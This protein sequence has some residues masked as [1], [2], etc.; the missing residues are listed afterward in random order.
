MAQTYVWLPIEN[1][2][3]ISLELYLPWLQYNV[4]YCIGILW[5][6]GHQYIRRNDYDVFTDLGTYLVR[7]QYLSGATRIRFLGGG[8]GVGFK[9]KKLFTDVWWEKGVRLS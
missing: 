9:K 5:S 3:P 1:L 2:N 7:V 4:G 8:R 6:R